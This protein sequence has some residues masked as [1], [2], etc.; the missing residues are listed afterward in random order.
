MTLAQRAGP[1]PPFLIE[2]CKMNSIDP[3]AWPSATLTA[4]VNC[5]K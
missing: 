1:S 3:H 5:F 2:T 4:I